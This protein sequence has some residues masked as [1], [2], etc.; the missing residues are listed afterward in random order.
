MDVTKLSTGKSEI[1]TMLRKRS[2]KHNG[3][4][5]LGLCLL[6]ATGCQDIVGEGGR[7]EAQ[8]FPPLEPVSTGSP[9]GLPVPT[10]PPTEV[11]TLVSTGR[12]VPRADIFSLHP[13]EKAFDTKARNEAIFRQ[14]GGAF[15]GPVFVPKPEPVV[16][17]AFEPQPFRRL[18]GILVGD[19]VMAIIDM[20]PGTQT[21]VIRPGMQIPNSPWR[22]VSIDEEK[23]ILRRSGNTRP[24]EI[25]VRLQG[26]APGAGGNLGAPPRIDVGGAQ[27][28]ARNPGANPGGAGGRRGGGR[29]GGGA[30]GID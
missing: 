4:P 15:F 7:P 9:A 10:A 6:A 20:G 29:I 1:M 26:P 17:D 18:A 19:S 3:L 16:I 28:P 14:T 12:T 30:G 5:I 23:A 13:L 24:K 25:I 11:L 21:Q 8:K 22:V 27:A 2:L